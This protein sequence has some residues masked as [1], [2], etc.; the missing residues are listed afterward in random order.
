[1][2][3]NLF[4]GL[5]VGAVLALLAGAG[6]IAKIVVSPVIKLRE[7]IKELQI[8]LDN[9]KEHDVEVEQKMKA[10]SLKLDNIDNNVETIDKR[11][12]VIETKF[13]TQS[14]ARKRT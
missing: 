4:M 9:S 10:Y 3:S 1:M 13:K 14:Q 5:F 6:I 2:D 7:E 11:L 8:K 12:I